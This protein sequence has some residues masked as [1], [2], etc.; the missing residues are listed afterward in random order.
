MFA[1]AIL[2][3]SAAAFLARRDRDSLTVIYE[4]LAVALAAY[5]HLA[6]IGQQL[7]AMVDGVLDQR[8]N[9]QARDSCAHRKIRDV[10][11]EC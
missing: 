4:V 11:G 1:I 3:P 9:G 7:D 8:L 2:L 6:A 10:P 5:R